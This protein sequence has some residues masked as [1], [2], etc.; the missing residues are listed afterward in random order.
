[1][2]VP[3]FGF[4]RAHPPVLDGGAAAGMKILVLCLS[5]SLSVFVLTAKATCGSKCCQFGLRIACTYWNQL[6]N[7]CH[8]LR[9][10]HFDLGS[11]CKVCIS[12][13][14]KKLGCLSGTKF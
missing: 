14:R 2:P 10:K 6:S 3:V 9:V 7:E 5:L 13:I 4:V 1:M 11:P 8:Q 12:G